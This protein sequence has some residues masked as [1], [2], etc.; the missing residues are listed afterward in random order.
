MSCV[1]SSKLWNLHDPW[2]LHQSKSCSLS[3]SWVCGISCSVLKQKHGCVDSWLYMGS[4]IKA[5]SMRFSEKSW[6]VC[7]Y[8]GGRFSLS[9]IFI[10][11]C[12]FKKN[13]MKSM[14]KLWLR[15][16]RTCLW[17]R[18]SGFNPRVG[19]ILWRREWQPTLVFLPGNSH[20]Q[21]SLAGLWGC[22]VGHDWATFT[23][24]GCGKIY[25]T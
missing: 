18:G 1:T 19:K 8:G 20:G 11:N 7:V 24:L 25:I 6:L 4:K 9:I 10:Q 3:A 16:Q 2:F 23:C 17:G 13:L 5:Q 12:E 22:R 15:W 14:L 21:W